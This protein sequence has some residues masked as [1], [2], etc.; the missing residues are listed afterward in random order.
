MIM[1]NSYILY[2]ARLLLSCPYLAWLNCDWVG[3]T[4]LY[5]G[6]TARYFVT[7]G[8]VKKVSYALLTIGL[9]KPLFQLPNV[10]NVEDCA[11]LCADEPGCLSVTHQPST[12][13][14]WLKNK[15]FGAEPQDMDGVNSRNLQCGGN[16]HGIKKQTVLIR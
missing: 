11:A 7:I 16:L 3:K 12:S 8:L 15:R 10:R 13:K 2:R 4:L 1:T 5:N 6:L 9:I 14:C